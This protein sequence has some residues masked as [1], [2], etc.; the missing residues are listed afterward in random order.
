MS[1][2]KLTSALKAVIETVKTDTDRIQEIYDYET[3]KFRGYPAVTIVP[4]S[5]SNDYETTKDNKR[6]YTFTIRIFLERKVEAP[7]DQESRLRQL[8][9][10]ML[11]A[12]DSEDNWRLTSAN[13]PAGYT[14]IILQPSPSEWGYVEAETAILRYAEIK[15]KVQVSVNCQTI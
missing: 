15:A 12:F 11:D 6:T 2:V 14:L 8:M 1:F 5:N 10:N 3:S 4:S 7:Q 9:D 13:L